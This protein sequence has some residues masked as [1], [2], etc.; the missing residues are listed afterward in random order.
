MSDDVFTTS[1][2]IEA[3][4][5]EVF[6]YLTDAALMIRWMGDWADLA[7]KPGGVF[8][9]DIAGVRIRG[10]YVVV[11]A[12]NRLVFTWGAPGNDT[13]SLAWRLPGP[14]ATLAPIRG[15]AP[16]A[17]VADPPDSMSHGLLTLAW[18]PFTP[19]PSTCCAG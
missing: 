13:S 19:T 6:P 3:P 14:A 2:R 18:C 16:D 4:P 5:D 10:E 7:A 12:P 15:L 1:V 11:E 17:D 9:V 8:A